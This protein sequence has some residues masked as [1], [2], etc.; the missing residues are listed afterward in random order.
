MK[1][2]KNIAI[3]L[4]II[5]TSCGNNADEYDYVFT[6]KIISITD[7]LNT[8]NQIEKVLDS[9]GKRD[10]KVMRIQDFKSRHPEEM[11]FCKGNADSLEINQSFHKGD[12]DKNGYTDILAI[13]EYFGFS[14]V[15]IQSYPNDSLAVNHLSRRNFQFCVFPKLR[16]DGNIDLFFDP[17]FMNEPISKVTLTHKF[18]DFIEYNP[19]PINK[20]IERIEYK[21]SSCYGR[22]PIFELS[23]NKNGESK[24]IAEAYNF[25]KNR[26]WDFSNEGEFKSQL[27]EKN[28]NELTEILNYIDFENLSEGYGV[29]WNHQQSCDLKVYYENGRTK[30]ISDYGLLGTYGLT[31]L[32]DRLFEIRINQNWI[33]K[34]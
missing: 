24:F 27:N 22:C 10:F 1:K 9:L 14:I 5:S 3:T 34:E 4:L 7:S 17:F 32:Y 18:G 12:F 19:N 8:E 16:K 31:M 13:G 2:L 20:K 30:E 6:P 11:K 28:W 29:S 23:L 33:E 15:S 21:T 26:I 25:D